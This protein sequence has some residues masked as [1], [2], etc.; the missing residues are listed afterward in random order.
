M[1]IVG[2][3][4]IVEIDDQSK[5]CLVTSPLSEHEPTSKS[6]CLCGSGRRFRLCCKDEY[7]KPRI[8]LNGLIAA[9]KCREYLKEK[10]AHLTWYRLCHAAHTKPYL[11]INPQAGQRIL[12]VDIAAM[13]DLIGGLLS[14]YAAC[15]ILHEFPSAIEHLRHAVDSERWKVHLDY[16]LT[17][18]HFLYQNDLT[19]AR[20][21]AGQYSWESLSDVPFL[22]MWLSLFAERLDHVEV[23][24]VA[25]RI[26]SMSDDD[27][28]RLQYGCLIGVQ[29]CLLM[30]FDK[31]IPIISEAIHEYEER[32]PETS[33][34]IF[35]QHRLADAYKILADCSGETDH[36][37]SA[38]IRFQ[39]L[40]AYP[41]FTPAGLAMVWMSIGECYFGLRRFEDSNNAYDR[42]LSYEKTGLAQAFQARTLIAMGRYPEARTTLKEVITS[43]LSRAN[44]LDF[45][46]STARLA[47]AT[48]Q[49]EDIEHALIALKASESNDPLF[50]NMVR[51]LLIELYEI[52]DHAGNS[53]AAET[54][55]QRLN[56]YVLLRPNFMG[57]GI[58]FNAIFKD[59]LEPRNE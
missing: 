35:G 20:K 37:E 47:L 1:G 55:L 10:R 34:E 48:S 12:N 5:D 46:I 15:S 11:V 14:G 18:L 2:D 43:A 31:G 25:E 19:S 40:A 8:S 50:Q 23:T 51:D 16:Q 13:S 27:E 49:S 21:I 42:S 33:R 4:T 56:R 32:V 24:A 58:D 39:S 41:D 26:L 44:R 45:A 28:I 38:L 9:G 6:P 17:S 53:E 59:M 54:I 29:H 36:T 22:T 30:N 52:R 3:L 7:A 57:L